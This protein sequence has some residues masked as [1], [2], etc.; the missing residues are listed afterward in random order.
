MKDQKRQKRIQE[1]S[2]Q[3][4]EAL[5]EMDYAW[6]DFYDSALEMMGAKPLKKN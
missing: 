6:A 3:Y 5:A 2:R 1:L 4:W